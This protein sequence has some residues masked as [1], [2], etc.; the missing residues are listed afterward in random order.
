MED[1]NGS[2]LQ[3]SGGIFDLRGACY[4]HDLR[5]ILAVTPFG[6]WPGVLES[7]DRDKTQAI[8][9]TGNGG[10]TFRL[11]GNSGPGEI[12]VGPI[13]GLMERCRRKGSE[14]WNFPS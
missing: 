10:E 5:L 6:V 13:V 3:A 11:L 4:F 8:E 1:I 7:I 14:G 9:W 12:V 2:G